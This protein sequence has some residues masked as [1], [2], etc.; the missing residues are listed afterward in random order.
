MFTRKKM[1]ATKIREEWPLNETVPSFRSHNRE[2]LTKLD[3][4]VK[5]L[6][7]PKY[8]LPECSLGPNAIR[9]FAMS[10]MRERRRTQ[11]LKD[12]STTESEVE[13]ASSDTSASTCSSP[14]SKTNFGEYFHEGMNSF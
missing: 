4:F 12:A 8:T 14:E 10:Q 6:D 11:K 3:N 13:E 2:E 5:A 9:D 7:T 1:I